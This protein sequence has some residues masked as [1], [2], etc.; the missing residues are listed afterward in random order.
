MNQVISFD[1]VVYFGYLQLKYKDPKLMG[2][3][4]DGKQ[5]KVKI[6]F[7]SRVRPEDERIRGK[8]RITQLR[9]SNKQRTKAQE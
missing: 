8:N 6:A 9:L 7:Q 2:H 3:M 1:R 5:K 4:E